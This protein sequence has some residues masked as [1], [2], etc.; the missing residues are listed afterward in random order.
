MK[1]R[2]IYYVY[3]TNGDFWMIGRCISVDNGDSDKWHTRGNA[4]YI[5]ARDSYNEDESW[6]YSSS[7]RTYRE[8]TPEEQHWFLACEKARE[9]IP[10][11]Q[12]KLSY[13][14]Y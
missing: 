3:D 6:S 9:F 11:E 12:V 7:D 4:T 14:I 10:K 5:T 1:E 13:E 2:K 8:A